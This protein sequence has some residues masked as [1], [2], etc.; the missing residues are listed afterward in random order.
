MLQK[1]DNLYADTIA[2]TIA[3]EYFNKPADY[4]AAAKAI[5]EILEKKAKI[6]LKNAY[7][8]DGSGLSAHNL[9]SARN[10]FDV[11]N[12]I[13]RNDAQLNL[14]S[15]FPTAGENGTLKYRASVTKAPLKGNVLAKTGSLQNVSNLAGFVLSKNDNLIPFVIM[16]NSITYPQNVRD[17][18]KKQKQKSPHFDYEREILNQIY[19]ER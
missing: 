15:L 11:L 16:E 17:K 5:V 10:L 13:K 4:K 3:Y 2:K 7:L 9:L 8:V 6:N 12:Y 18:I 1:S 14:I 19:S